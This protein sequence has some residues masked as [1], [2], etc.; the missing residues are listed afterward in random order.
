MMSDE[1]RDDVGW[2]MDLILVVKTVKLH[3]VIIGRGSQISPSQKAA[4]IK[5][6][7]PWQSC[8]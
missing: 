7:T 4:G 2:W 1:I 5:F 6:C 3:L 8:I